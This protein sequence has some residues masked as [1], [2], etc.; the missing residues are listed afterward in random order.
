MASVMSKIMTENKDKTKVVDELFAAGAHFGFPKSRR[1]PSIAEYIFGSKNKNDIFDLEKTS[2]SLEKA[3]EFVKKLGIEKASLLLV[4]GK[5]EAREAVAK[6]A[7]AVDRP[8]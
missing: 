3:L 5:S 7:D 4:G 1:H 6:A 8:Y 2:L